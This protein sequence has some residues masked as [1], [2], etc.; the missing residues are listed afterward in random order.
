MKFYLKYNIFLLLHVQNRLWH[1]D[2]PWQL[3]INIQMLGQDLW[4]ILWGN[5]LSSVFNIIILHAIPSYIW[6]MLYNIQL[7]QYCNPSSKIMA[8]SLQFMEA[9][10]FDIKVQSYCYGTHVFKTRLQKVFKPNLNTVR[11]NI[12]KHRTVSWPS[13]LYN[14]NTYT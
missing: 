2:C 1:G 6:F 8:N 4:C 13:Y 9:V 7:Y 14:E 3:F 5:S 12:Y 10:Q 11:H